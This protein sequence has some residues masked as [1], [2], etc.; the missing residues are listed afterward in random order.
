MIRNAAPFSMDFYRQ[1]VR[2][3][4]DKTRARHLAVLRWTTAPSFY[5]K[6]V[7]QNGRAMEPE[8][9]ARD[10]RRDPPGGARLHR[11][12]VTR[13]AAI[14]TGTD[15]RPQAPNWINVD[16]RRDPQEKRICGFAVCRREPRVDHAQ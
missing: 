14:E 15:V 16:I 6:T 5:V 12:D 4:F 11:R 10:A 13:A 7:D 8:V 9:L 3:T 1:F 2:G